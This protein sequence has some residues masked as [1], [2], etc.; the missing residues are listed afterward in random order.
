M[1]DDLERVDIAEAPERLNALPAPARRLII[2]V[3]AAAVTLAAVVVALF[4]VSSTAAWWTVPVFA[5]LIAGGE[6]FRI[7]LPYR[8]GGMATFTLGDAGLT[9]TLL[10]AP[11]PHV[12][13]ATFVGILVTEL[14]DRGP[15]MKAVYN[16]AHYTLGAAAAAI[17]LQGLAARPGPVE[18]STAGAVA[19][20][21]AVSMGL[22]T[23][24]VAAI[25]AASGG[26]RLESTFGRMLPT[27]A[28]LAA[29]N[30]CIGLLSVLLLASH[31]WA[32]AALAAPLLL[33]HYSSRQRIIAQM[34]AER[35]RALV[36]VEQRLSAADSPEEV[37]EHL[38]SGVGAI[39]G[40]NAAVWREGR[41]VTPVPSGSMPCPV[42][43]DLTVTL[44]AR[45]PA[46]G[47]DVQGPCAA[48]GLGGGVL[49]AWEGDLE[50]AGDEAERWLERLARSGRISF[51]RAAAAAELRQERAILRAVIDGTGDGILVLDADSVIRLWN[52]A[53]A[54]LAGWD[55][56]QALSRAVT[57]VLGDGPW[58]TD[59][60]HD[61][62]RPHN[63][64]VWRVSI[65]AIRDQAHGELRVLAVHDVSA[66]RRVAR[67]KDDMLSVVSHEL[68]TPLTPIKASAQLLR[69]RYE[70][71]EPAQRDQ[72]LAQ[73]EHRADH[74]AR[75]VEDL[76]LV[77]Q[78][79]EGAG[80]RP[81]VLAAAT[82]LAQV[83]ADD[84][85]QL[86]MTRPTHQISLDCP[87]TLPAVTDA[88]RVRQI[89]DNLVDNACKFSMPGSR[90]QVT[91]TQD[92]DWA[93]LRVA[94][95]GRG[96]PAEDLTRVFERFERVEDPLLMTT[97][98]AGL[99]LYIVQALVGALGGSVTM[100][101]VLGAGTT[102]IVRLPLPAPPSSGEHDTQPAPLAADRGP[103]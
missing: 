92:G 6:A 18:I 16:I 62:V 63:D 43:A 38:A 47:P 56:A 44:V 28:L 102:V 4:P 22:N 85:E 91:L 68:R 79:S 10:L 26:P 27:S 89:V 46:L 23:F 98:G 72:L 48:I 77:G 49:V 42:D 87:P 100:D 33:L 35:S 14:L 12:V 96:I 76:L 54:A 57:D 95:Q 8:R 9:A 25:I 67:M 31:Q 64:R 74:L 13:L 52:P 69:R 51:E 78:L 36:D 94:D 81:S 29:G 55:D 45:G 5:A 40:C 84:V 99:G 103:H 80:A 41:W 2:G 58:A 24:A 97:S 66:E 83:L 7:N 37:A 15:R 34:E 70:R 75:L 30:V 88:L 93:E 73:I 32:L 21:I 39:L 61:V 53:M 101:S 17:I 20:A 59:G 65:A 71:M 3:T 82:D 11:A 86:A 50:V 90:V 60:I 1:D 19:L